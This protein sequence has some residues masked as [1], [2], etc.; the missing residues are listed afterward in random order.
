MLPYIR[1]MENTGILA[2]G[3]KIMITA[4]RLRTGLQLRERGVKEKPE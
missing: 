3:Y 1:N 2:E 4:R